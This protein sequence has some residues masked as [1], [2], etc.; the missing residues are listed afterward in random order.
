MP[1]AALRAGWS[2]APEKARFYTARTVFPPTFRTTVHGGKPLHSGIQA[3][4]SEVRGGLLLERFTGGEV[5]VSL[6]LRLQVFSRDIGRCVLCGLDTLALSAA[7]FYVAGKAPEWGLNFAAFRWAV[8]VS[9]ARWPQ[10]TWEADHITPRMFGGPDSVENLR[11]LCL[12]CHLAESR[13][14]R[15][16]LQAHPA[17]RISGERWE[18]R[19]GPPVWEGERER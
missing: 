6:E 10:E 5:Q 13:R 12:G 2:S 7:L 16:W 19:V 18:S 4:F 9:A 17:W 3:R 8:G 15:E 11:T 1:P 14:L